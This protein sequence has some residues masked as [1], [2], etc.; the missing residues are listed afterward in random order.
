MHACVVCN[1]LAW[2]TNRGK[3]HVSVDKCHISALTRHPGKVYILCYFFLSCSESVL[4][5]FC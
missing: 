1:A 2:L 3:C 5:Q 4:Q